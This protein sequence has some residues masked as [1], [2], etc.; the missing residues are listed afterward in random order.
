MVTMKEI[1][2]GTMRV[3]AMG[4]MMGTIEEEANEY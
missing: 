3:I 2:Q 4:A 1:G